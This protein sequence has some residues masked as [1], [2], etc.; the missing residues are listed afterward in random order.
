MAE[1]FNINQLMIKLKKMMK[2]L[3]LQQDEEM[4]AASLNSW[5][6]VLWKAVKPRD[7]LYILLAELCD[8]PII[9]PI[10]LWLSWV[11]VF[12]SCLRIS[13]ATFSTFSLVR[14]VGVR[15]LLL[16]GIRAKSQVLSILRSKYLSPLF[17]QPLLGI[18]LSC[19]LN[20]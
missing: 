10:F 9:L 20:L 12:C 16:P 13:S 7:C 8:I 15:F 1:I 2:L 18:S 6:L 17:F 19:L 14:T 5:T 11:A 3:W 4:V